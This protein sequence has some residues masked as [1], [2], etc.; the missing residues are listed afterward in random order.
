L[1]GDAL[2][3]AL[4][5]TARPD[6]RTDPNQRVDQGTDRAMDTLRGKRPAERSPQQSAG[7]QVRRP[8]HAGSVRSGKEA[9][10]AFSRIEG[11]IAEGRHREAEVERLRAE[12]MVCR[13]ELTA[14]EQEC[15]RSEARLRDAFR[16]LQ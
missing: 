7:A 15:E 3:R 8:L 14:R 5:I 6:Q 9:Q 2:P 11:V 13:A 12:H 4:H 10:R 1:K 16:D